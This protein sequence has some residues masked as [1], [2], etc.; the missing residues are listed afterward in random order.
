M[1]TFYYLACTEC[2]KKVDFVGRW[3]NRVEWLSQPD[4]VLQ[5]M[6][7]HMP[8]I[9]SVKIVSQHDRESSYE[10]ENPEEEGNG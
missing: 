6:D 10:D 2:K 9:S 7:K 4:D 1:S 5:F 8:C 3:I